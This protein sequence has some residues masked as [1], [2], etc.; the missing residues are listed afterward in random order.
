MT[1]PGSVT[2]FVDVQQTPDANQA[3]QQ[4]VNELA[5]SKYHSQPDPQGNSVTSMP[6]IGTPTTAATTPPPKAATASNSSVI[7]IIIGAV[8]LV[9][10]LV[11]VLRAFGKPRKDDE[12]K[13]KRK[14]KDKP[15]SSAD[16][17]E[18]P[19][20]DEVLYG[21]ALHRRT[22]QD[23]ADAGRWAEA[24][25]ERFRAVIGAL[26]ELGLLPERPERT[27]D[28]A[29]RDAGEVLPGHLGPLTV[30]ARA[31]DEVEY[32]EYVGSPEAYAG[33]RAV[34]E[35]IAASSAA[36]RPGGRR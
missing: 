15:A 23:A 14:K 1:T 9:L 7:L 3:Q 21:A 36:S 6:T 28:E 31:F 22:A 17:Q 16:E 2:V 27:A 12:K 24:I 18:R 19:A 20:F 30:A 32:G 29:A 34:D 10:V 13:D 11:F 33:I 35:Q 26:D 8:V 25:R 4:A 5:K